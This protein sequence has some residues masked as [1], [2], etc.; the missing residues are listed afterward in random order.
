MNTTDPPADFRSMPHGIT[1]YNGRG[2][3]CSSLIGPCGCGAWHRIG[4]WPS[5]MVDYIRRM[6]G[7]AETVG[8]GPV[9]ADLS[10]AV[11]WEKPGP[12]RSPSA[13]WAAWLR[14]LA[15]RMEGRD[16]R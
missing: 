6:D 12:G 13:R 10:D 3:P 8:T 1:Q 2:E 4:D 7:G 14:R 9:A 5:E 11:G 16:D 15:D